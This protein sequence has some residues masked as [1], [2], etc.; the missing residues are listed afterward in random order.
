MTGTPPLEDLAE[1][2]AILA[3]VITARLATWTPPPGSP[4]EWAP[5]YRLLADAIELHDADPTEQLARLG[6]TVAH[7]DERAR[8]IVLH[9]V[10]VAAIAILT[11]A[12]RDQRAPVDVLRQIWELRR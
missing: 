11:L 2:V 10:A 5:A 3:E 4:L 1:Q 7:V 8:L 9:L 6:E 12:D